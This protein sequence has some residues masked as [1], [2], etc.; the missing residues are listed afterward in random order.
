[1]LPNLGRQSFDHSTE[2]YTNYDKDDIFHRKPTVDNL[3]AK[4]R[5][6]H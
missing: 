1:M 5:K 6:S 3:L 2:P 4:K